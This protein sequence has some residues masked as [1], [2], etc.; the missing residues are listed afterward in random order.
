MAFSE[1][2]LTILSHTEWYALEYME[3]DTMLSGA[4]DL[5]LNGLYTNYSPLFEVSQIFFVWVF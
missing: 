3:I 2:Q 4:K 5:V 1:E